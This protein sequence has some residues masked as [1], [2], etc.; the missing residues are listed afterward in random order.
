M[1]QPL[2]LT[3][4]SYFSDVF[5]PPAEQV[6]THQIEYSQAIWNNSPFLLENQE[7]GDFILDVIRLL[8]PY[9]EVLGAARTIQDIPATCYLAHRILNNSKKKGISTVIDEIAISVR[10]SEILEKYP[11][12]KEDPT[13]KSNILLFVFLQLQNAPI[14]PHIASDLQA[15]LLR[16][17]SQADF[18]RSDLAIKTL[19][20]LISGPLRVFSSITEPDFIRASQADDPWV[21]LRL[22]TETINGLPRLKGPIDQNPLKPGTCR[23]ILRD[24]LVLLGKSDLLGYASEI[25]SIGKSACRL[26]DDDLDEN[27]MDAH[28]SQVVQSTKK[29]LEPGSSLEPDNWLV[30]HEYAR[31]SS[32]R[33]IMQEYLSPLQ[34]DAIPIPILA[35]L[36]S[37]ILQSKSDISPDRFTARVLILSILLIGRP[38]AFFQAMR[39]GKFPE[40]GEFLAEPIY[41]PESHCIFFPAD[42]FRDEYPLSSR[43]SSDLYFPITHSWAIPL[44]EPL[45]PL[46]ERLTKINPSSPLFGNITDLREP[47]SQ[48]TYWMRQS[49]CHLPPV[50]ES[51]LRISCRVL[52]QCAGGM[53]PLLF[54]F[55][56]GQ[57]RNSDFVPFLYTTISCSWLGNQYLASFH[58]MWNVLRQY[59]SDLPEYSSHEFVLP[60]EPYIGSPYRPRM[61]RVRHVISRLQNSIHA[62]AN[63]EDLHNDRTMLVLFLLGFNAGLR[64]MEVTSLRPEQVDLENCY[65]GKPLPWI[66]LDKSKTNR[67]T[68]ASRIVPLPS[69]LAHLLKSV[70]SPSRDTQA[71]YFLEKGKKKLLTEATFAEHYRRLQTD[72]SWH[73]GRHFVRS[74][75]CEQGVEYDVINPLLGHQNQGREL[76]N[77]HLSNNPWSVWSEQASH[78]QR[79]ACELG[80]EEE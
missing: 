59:R 1:G 68:T 71:F 22:L 53:D 26:L 13:R 76:L 62:S 7:S 31:L 44:P 56:S 78:L 16:A 8:Q 67:W 72:L 18:Q 65:K 48:V 50:S 5:S 34:W 66:A 51:R 33:A 73:S 35:D 11:V 15:G 12:T 42:A 75:L 77:P 41:I 40:P 32:E 70:L 17:L 45:H 29:D 69:Q 24:C 9:G 10:S 80:V 49:L 57:W 23:A 47:F 55:I 54:N 38:A 46:W 60:N 3:G 4:V 6:T 63:G 37:I 21:F 52:S 36:A 27:E 30:D 61:D 64:R 74:W 14:L 20:A 2:L 25:G 79:L 28:F 39:V 43:P 19:G 58:R